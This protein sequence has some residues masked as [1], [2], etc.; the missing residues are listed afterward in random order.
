ME[1]N[2]PNAL[3]RGSSRFDAFNRRIIAIDEEWFPSFGEWVLQL[4]SILMILAKGS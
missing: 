1:L 2:T 3:S 4:E